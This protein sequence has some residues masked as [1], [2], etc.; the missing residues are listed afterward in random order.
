MFCC[1]G[2]FSAIVIGVLSVLYLIWLYHNS[3]EE[4]Q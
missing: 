1:I 3:G 2:I 4:D